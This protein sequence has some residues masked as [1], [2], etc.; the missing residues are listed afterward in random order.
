MWLFAAYLLASLSISEQRRYHEEAVRLARQAEQAIEGL[1]KTRLAML[2]GLARAA[3]SPGEDA[4]LLR[5]EARRLVSGAGERIVLRDLGARLYFDTRA[6]KDDGRPVDPLSG[7]EL[8]DLQAGR[9]HVSGV[10]TDPDTGA[11]SIAVEKPVRLSDGN[12]AAMVMTISTATLHEVL[13]PA[14][15]KGWI[16]GVG[17]RSGVYITRSERHEE[18]SGKP[19]LTDYLDKARGRSGTFTAENQFGQTL[20]AGYLRS[21]FTGWLYGANVPLSVVEAPLRKSIYGILATGALAMALSLA[22]AYLVGQTMTRQTKELVA[23]AM[24]LGNKEPVEPFRSRLFEFSLIGEAFST[25]ETMLQE[26]THELETVLA[27]APVAVW[28]TYDPTA[29]LVIRNRYAAELMGIDTTTGAGYGKVDHVTET[30]AYKD[31]VEVAREDRPL[32]RAM[33]GEQIEQQ[34]YVYRLPNGA[35]RV[36]LSSARPIRD[37]AGQIVGAVQIS[38]DISERKRDEEQRRL[39]ARELNHRVRNNLAMVQAIAKQTVRGTR[40][41]DL[42]GEEFVARIAALARANDILG[43]D[44][45]S[46]GDLRQVVE[47]SIVVQADMTRVDVAGD[48]VTLRPAL[49]MAVTLSMHELTTN[50]TKYG[51]LSD[52]DGR[53]SIGW[54]TVAGKLRIRWSESGGPPVRAPSRKGFGSR[55][56]QRI[57]AAE[58]GEAAIDYAE[59]GL[60]CTLTFSL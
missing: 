4:A 32:S 57:T 34:E 6:E 30:F 51:A 33:R 9:P 50:A 43:S 60:R 20:L 59:D 40:R 1:L 16:V 7:A 24:A 55:L 14:V 54:E 21:D 49:V 25:A 58:G 29:H 22:L 23:R 18:V 53:V 17:D 15:P 11:P 26:R 46:E 28:F 3:A 27:I 45:S 37:A 8:T 39:L 35:Q 42:A 10:Y 47:G 12:A 44:N 36:L 38:L 41:L 19:G 5:I 31:G 52:D 13:V 56:L 48:S 2:E